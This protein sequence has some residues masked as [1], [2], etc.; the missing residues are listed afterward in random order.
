VPS[1]NEIIEDEVAE[2]AFTLAR[3][4]PKMEEEV[5]ELE[6]QATADNAKTQ[7]VKKKIKALKAKC[8]NLDV[9]ILVR[10]SFFTNNFKCLRTI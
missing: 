5:K 6:N 10:I 3:S 2:F 4:I 1:K 8:T 7:D 9:G